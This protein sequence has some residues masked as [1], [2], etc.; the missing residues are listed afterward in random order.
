M[1]VGANSSLPHNR[2]IIPRQHLYGLYG[3]P[4]QHPIFF[5]IWQ[6][7][8]ITISLAPDVRLR[9]N[10]LRWVHDDEGYALVH[11]GE[12]PRTLIFELKFD[13]WSRF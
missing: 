4:S 6:F 13:P 11:F 10:E 9:Q 5:P 2:T 8:Q 3:L 7:E 1:S 12:I